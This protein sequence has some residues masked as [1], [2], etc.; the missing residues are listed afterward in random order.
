MKRKGYIVEQI[1]DTDNLRLAFWKA[2]KG[3]SMKQ[4]VML[5]RENLDARL[6]Q[7]REQL[8][9][10]SYR[11]GNYRYFTI[12]DPKRRIICA[13]PFAERVVHHAIMNVCATDF[14]RRQ[15]PYSYA[16][17]KNKGTFA[18][19]EQA[20]L[21][22]KKYQWFLKLDVRKYFD[23]I[24]HEILFEKLQRMY[25]DKSLLSLFRKIIDSYHAG[26]DRGLPIGNLASQYFANHYLSY[27]DRHAVEQLRIPAYLRYMDDMLLWFNDKSEL[28]EKGKQYE[29]FIR[30]HLKLELK[31]FVHNKTG[32]GLPALGFILYPDR[33]R[34]NRRSRQR[35]S[36]K[37]RQNYTLLERG[38]ISESEFGVRTLSLYGF[39]A[40]A[41]S[42]GLAK[43][44]MQKTGTDIESSNRVNRG[45]SWNNN[46]G[47]CRVANRNNN[48]P[49]NS[50]NNLGF[51][52]ACSSK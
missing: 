32:H 18:A 40:H 34:L 14:D 37:L 31:P 11:F 23:S 8:L 44:V 24:D 21:Y 50:N 20:A 30:E 46:A 7:I 3:K 38:E 27:A 33:I 6:L 4:E 35:F 10:N 2:Q 28:L 12:H 48:S 22:Q 25:K 47:N 52:L 19:L 42:K 9:D 29:H 26:D 51:R 1:A 36:T 45:G 5:F 15:I 16:C 49:D 43:H 39:I 13:A 17:R 41:D